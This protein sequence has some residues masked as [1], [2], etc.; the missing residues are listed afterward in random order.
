MLHWGRALCLGLLSTSM[1]DRLLGLPAGHGLSHNM[2]DHT[3]DLGGLCKNSPPTIPAYTCSHMP[4]PQ[5]G[6]LQLRSSLLFR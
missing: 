4:C 3:Y 5:V 6:L 1:E 2:Y